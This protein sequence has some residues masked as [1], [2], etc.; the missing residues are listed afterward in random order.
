MHHSS[1]HFSIRTAAEKIVA[2]IRVKWPKGYLSQTE[3]SVTVTLSYY[4]NEDNIL[5]FDVVVDNQSGNEFEAHSGQWT[6]TSQKFNKDTIDIL[7]PEDPEA[8]LLEFDKVES[9][10]KRIQNS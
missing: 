7:A 5:V 8:I 1:S 4:R 9:I 3:N 10:Q 2:G 6:I